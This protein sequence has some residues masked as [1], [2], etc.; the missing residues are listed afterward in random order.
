MVAMARPYV[1]LVGGR[2]WDVCARAP[3]GFSCCVHMC[4]GDV[5]DR[6]TRHSRPTRVVCM[7][8]GERCSDELELRYATAG[9]LAGT[10]QTSC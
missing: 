5:R 7:K 1:R 8:D 6:A 2:V 4:I 9:A 3:V 10:T